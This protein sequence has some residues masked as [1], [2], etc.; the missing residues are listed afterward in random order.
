MI[1]RN[2][3]GGKRQ[4]E[5]R[6]REKGGRRG[7]RRKGVREVRSTEKKRG[8]VSKAKLNFGSGYGKQAGRA[9]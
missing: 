1:R 4:V 8:G 7:G 5:G 2:K 9:S 3:K 6:R